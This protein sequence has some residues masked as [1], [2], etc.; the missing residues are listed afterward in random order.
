ME[1][2]LTYSEWIALAKIYGF[3]IMPENNL[4]Y[5]TARLWNFIRNLELL[6]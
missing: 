1:W 5:K 2:Q 6:C 4:M 3:N